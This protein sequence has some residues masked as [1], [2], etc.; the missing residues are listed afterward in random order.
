MSSNLKNNIEPV[1]DSALVH[2]V[3]S[4]E[5]GANTVKSIYRFYSISPLVEELYCT[6]VCGRGQ[7]ILASAD[8]KLSIQLVSQPTR[9]CCQRKTQNTVNTVFF[10]A[11][12]LT[13]AYRNS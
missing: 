7:G 12:I 10:L 11:V 8:S 6:A 5:A 3:A 4:V 1:K 9:P 13:A 2:D